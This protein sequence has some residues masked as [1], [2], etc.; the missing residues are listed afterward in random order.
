MY[1]DVMLRNIMNPDF[2]PNYKEI[3]RMHHYRLFAALLLSA[4]VT[5]CDRSPIPRDEALARELVLIA[6][7]HH[8][9]DQMS[10]EDYLHHLSSGDSVA[11][12]I[13]EFWKK[14]RIE[15]NA[16]LARLGYSSSSLTWKLNGDWRENL[17]RFQGDMGLAQSGEYDSLTIARIQEAE[18]ALGQNEFEM[19]LYF[20]L[21]CADFVMA[22]GSWKAVEGQLM[23]PFQVVDIHCDRATRRCDV[24]TAVPLGEK[25]DQIDL[26]RVEYDI[27]RWDK[28]F[29]VAKRP[30]LVEDDSTETIRIDLRNERVNYI[31]LRPDN[32]ALIWAYPS[33]R[34][35]LQL[36][37]G[38]R[39]CTTAS[40]LNHVR[41]SV[42]E[43]K[44]FFS[45]LLAKNIRAS[46]EE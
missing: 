29:V 37:P 24:A 16:T 32:D 14:N 18:E 26:E 4:F 33:S 38:T 8:S 3:R 40:S 11:P 12:R 42:Y 20:F 34:V 39:Y 6:T 19:G 27:I 5:S 36:V 15:M 31:N 21:G 22:R 13:R 44:R 10:Y 30:P 41:D 43:R 17:K 23:W 1:G 2:A 45:S 28:D 35:V 25:F 46:M 7:A 9:G